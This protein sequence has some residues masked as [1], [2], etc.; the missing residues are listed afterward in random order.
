MASFEQFLSPIEKHHSPLPGAALF[1]DAS[2]TMSEAVSN[3]RWELAAAAM[4]L[5]I[6]AV[7]RGK[8]ANLLKEAFA[9]DSAGA[10]AGV[11]ALESS[12]SNSRGSLI[13]MEASTPGGRVLNGNAAMES[14]MVSASHA[15]APAVEETS[16]AGVRSGGTAHL[17]FAAGKVSAPLADSSVAGA[18]STAETDLR[19]L[20]HAVGDVDRMSPYE[21]QGMLK[22]AA[23]ITDRPVIAAQIDAGL[24]LKGF[25]LT[26]V[27]KVSDAVKGED[28]KAVGAALDDIFS[29]NTYLGRHRLYGG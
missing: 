28:P 15:G 24:P 21:I 14:K 23:A 13:L 22:G 1:E 4:A 11:K 26:Q 25:D 19:L 6:V 18:R 27:K 20:S 3:N 17:E 9:T 16:A 12:A 29:P 5:G 8:G 2:A 7:S 10:K